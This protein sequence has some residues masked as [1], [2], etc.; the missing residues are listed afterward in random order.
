MSNAD[1][2][3]QKQLE[4]VE[5]LKENRVYNPLEPAA[6]MQKMHKVW[7]LMQQAAEAQVES[8]TDE[9]LEMAERNDMVETDDE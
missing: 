8:L 1:L 3:I 4:F 5:W 9:L 6:T 7:E 2:V